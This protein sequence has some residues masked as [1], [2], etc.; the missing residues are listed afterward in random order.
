MGTYR[1]SSMKPS[2][3]LIYFKPIL[4]G[5]NRDGGLIWE[6]CLFNLEKTMVSALHK[7]LEYKVD[8]LK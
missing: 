2:G 8:E 1:K 5:L 6:E 4:G 3:G 7:E